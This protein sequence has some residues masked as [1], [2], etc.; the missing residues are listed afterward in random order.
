MKRVIL[1]AAT[2]CSVLARRHHHQPAAADL[3]HEATKTVEKTK[4][5]EKKKTVNKEDMVYDDAKYGFVFEVVRH[6]ARTP[7]NEIA[8]DEFTVSQGM[9]TPEGMR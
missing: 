8:L 6:G 1:L 9:L 7:F 2:L 5:I 4:P 3:V